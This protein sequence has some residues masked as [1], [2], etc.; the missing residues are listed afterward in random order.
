MRNTPL[1]S[2]I[3]TPQFQRGPA[4]PVAEDNGSEATVELTKKCTKCSQTRPIVE[5]ALYRSRSEGFEP[6]CRHCHREYHRAPGP[7]PG[8]KKHVE[9][10]HQEEISRRRAAGEELPEQEVS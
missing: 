9:T 6:R 2:A 3:P 8:P 7:R 4:Q 1:E 10:L 5:F